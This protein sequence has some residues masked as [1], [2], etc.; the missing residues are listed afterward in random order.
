M[1]A[2]EYVTMPQ[3]DRAQLEQ[4]E[5]DYDTQ[6]KGLAHGVQKDAIQNTFGTVFAWPAIHKSLC[7]G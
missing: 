5:R 7:N 3:D 2:Q 4:I 6:G 1:P